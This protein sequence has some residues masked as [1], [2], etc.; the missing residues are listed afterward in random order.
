MIEK[1]ILS[2][3]ELKKVRISECRKN[4][5]KKNGKKKYLTSKEINEIIKLYPDNF[6]WELSK[7]F[8]VAES[9]ILRIKRIYNLKKSQEILNASRFKKGHMP[10]NKGKSYPLINN[11]QFKPGHIPINTWKPVGTISL[12]S[13]YKRNQRYYYIKTAEPNKWKALH[14]LLWEQ[15]YGKIPKGMIIIFKDKNPLNCEIENLEMI[16]RVENVRRNYNREKARIAMKKLWNREKIRAKYG[17][18]RE[19]K[20][21]I[22]VC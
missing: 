16:S 3:Y 11:G 17:L 8:D 2:D 12:R 9:T 6:N 7:M 1:Y 14:R 21:R 19:T 5:H 22:P 10:D 4:S 20:L 13:N 15:K 18:R